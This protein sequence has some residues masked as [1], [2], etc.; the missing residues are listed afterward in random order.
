MGTGSSDARHSLISPDDFK[1]FTAAYTSDLLSATYSSGGFV[2]S[3]NGSWEVVWAETLNG[4]GVTEGGSSGSPIYS[5]DGF[6]IGTL[7]GGW[8]SCTAL[9]SEDY[10]GKFDFHW[11]KNGSAN[12]T[13]LK[14]WLDPNNTGIQ[15]LQGITPCD[16]D[17]IP[18]TFT[19]PSSV[20]INCDDDPNNLALTGD[21]IDEWDNCDVIQATYTDVTDPTNPC[22]IVITRTWS[23]VDSFGN[24][25][26]DQNQIITLVDN[27]APTFTQP[28]N[29][30]INCGDNPN[31]LILT[32]DVT[33]EADNCDISPLNATYSDKYDSADSC[34]V[35]ITRTWTLIDNCNNI[36]THDQIIQIS[37]SFFT[38]FPNPS[39]G[40]IILRF[41]EQAMGNIYILRIFNMLGQ[42]V[43]TDNPTINNQLYISLNHLQKGVYFL[44]IEGEHQRQTQKISLY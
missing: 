29:I 9:T 34:S 36:T 10:Y 43:Y 22:A 42:V 17:I 1:R 12:N 11:D 39:N 38:I 7:T 5:Q 32:G 19:A 3:T 15:I 18:P 16:F 25:A 2:G 27:T 6:I 31:N 20:I 40:Q 37:D 13:Q 35:L 8:A 23:L 26:V 30:I 44:E 41:N 33:D 24:A 14:P 21:V 28:V 4:H